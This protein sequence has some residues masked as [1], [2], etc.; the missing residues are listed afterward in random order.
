MRDALRRHD[1]ILRSAIDQHGGSVFKTVGDAFC[2]AFDGPLN[3]VKAMLAAQQA[4]AA[5]DFSA[6]DGLRVRAAIHTGT[7]DERDGDYF[8]PDVNRVSRLLAIG[9]GSQILLTHETAAS[10]EGDLPAEVS[11]LDLG[12]YHLKDF[13]EPQRVHQLVAPGL[14]KEFPPLRSLG[15]LPSDSSLVDTQFVYPLPSFTGRDEEFAG[16]DA[17]LACDGAIAVVH[18][19]GGV[20]KSSLAREYAWRNHGRHSVVWWLGAQSEDGIISSLVRLG[21]MFVEGLAQL[22]DR[23][24]AAQRVVNS[25]L[26]GFDKPVL[27]IFDNLE[28]E[29]LARSWLPGTGARAL[30][31]SRNASWATDVCMMALQTW[32]L[33][34][35]VKYLQRQSARSDLSTADARAIAIALGALPL[36]LSHAA[37]WLRGTRMATPAGYVAHVT[38]HLKNAPSHVEYPQS[39]FATF[40]TA[41]AQAEREAPGAAAVLCFAASFAPD[42]IP[43]E[44]FRQPLDGRA[45]R[46]RVIVPGVAALDLRAA[47]NDE[48]RLNGA[49]GALDR[50]SLLAFSDGSRTYSLH[51]LVQ[52]AGRNLM[53]ETAPLW[54]TQA[55]E[56]ANQ[57]FPT[58][59]FDAWPQCARLLPHAQAA[60]DASDDALPASGRLAI[61]CAE[62]LQHRAEFAQAERLFER[63]LETFERLSGDQQAVVATCLRGLAGVA[64]EQGRYGEAEPRFERALTILERKLGRR[65]P[66]VAQCLN[67]MA[68]LYVAQGR[69]A[70][71]ERCHLRA[72]GIWERALGPEHPDV[73]I[74]LSL[75]AHLYIQQGRYAEAE[76]LQMRALRIFE[77]AL[78]P[79]HLH[80]A[81]CLLHVAHLY[82]KQERYEQAEPLI[83][84]ALT[85]KEA[86][87]APEHPDLAPALSHLGEIYARQRRYDEALRLH[88]RALA[89]RENGLGPDHAEIAVSLTNLATVYMNQGRL[90]DAEHLHKRALSICERALGPDHR[91]VADSLNNLARVHRAQRRYAEAHAEQQRAVQ[92][93]EKA[94]GATH[95]DVAAALD[96]LAATT[97]EIHGLGL[98]G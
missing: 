81:T 14:P 52:L 76:A 21:A 82:M 11:L 77:K 80:L 66:D 28:D 27:L 2:S 94:L 49:L 61:K 3:A 20:G 44:L 54:Q 98:P 48:L 17:A 96:D 4:L 40:T 64:L 15:T 30:V 83:K 62:Y 34:T 78:G 69:Y 67:S 33:D 90:V 8:G 41:I 51:R 42:A 23:R 5:Q 87:L 91:R 1:A 68:V 57:A 75:R 22:A 31:T 50:L 97:S 19:L 38:E 95:P 65:H 74:S 85:I 70:E 24:A 10:L 59:D 12:A 37:A 16:L 36:A 79:N 58:V 63:A 47:L 71:A 6:V 92:M 72:A 45:S 60:L 86:V 18:G 55:I 56:V 39:V 73:A 26:R 89:I 32:D 84:R 35:A 88:T 53:A 29:R 46:L 13:P 7:A 93:L 43:D 9:H 25:I